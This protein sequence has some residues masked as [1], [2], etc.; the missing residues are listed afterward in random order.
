VPSAVAATSPL[1]ELET[2]ASGLKAAAT[3][4]DASQFQKTL[5]EL[6]TKLA[7][8]AGRKALT[9]HRADIEA[10]IRRLGDRDAIE[11]A[12]RA[13]DTST[14][15]KKCTALTRS[16]VTSLVRDQFTRE[17]DRLH[18]ERVTLNDLGGHKGKLRH[19]PAL[20]GAKMP[21]P[22]AQVLSEG[23]QTALGLAGYFT[24]AHFDGSRSAMVLDDPVTSLDHVRRSH[25]AARLAQFSK[26]RQVIVFT[27]DITFVGDIIKAAEA[28][29][30]TLTERCVQRRGDGVPGLCVTQYP[31]KARDV[32]KRLQ[33]LDQQLAEIKHERS[34]WSQERYESAV[35]EWAGKLSETWERLIS[36][37][38]VNQVFDHGTS[39]VRPK[40]FRLFARITDDDDRGFQESYSRCSQWARRHDKSPATNY[41][42]PEPSDMEQE[43]DHVR[44]WFARVKKYRN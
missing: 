29:N 15:T 8:L 20:L 28:E 37:E 16:H 44:G 12:R 1:T 27:H 11:S 19:K 21:K 6:V 23:E 7:E 2:L 25:V 31:W 3:S 38:I 42:P 17:T 9:D 36:V 32:S 18:L 5:S 41:V 39:E 4:I 34:G 10:E 30:V 40:M 22:V 43:L 14:I 13:T 33:D 24:E 26:D 35:A